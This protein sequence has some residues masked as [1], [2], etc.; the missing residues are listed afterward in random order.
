MEQII[1][2]GK[3]VA[4]Y[5]RQAVAAKIANAKARGLLTTLAVIVVGDDQACHVY[6]KRLVKLLTSLGGQVKEVLRPASTTQEEVVALV[7]KLNRNRYVT[8]ILPLLPMPPQIKGAE[9]AGIIAANKDVDCF[10]SSNMGEFY[11]GRNPWAPCT[12][13]ACLA[14]LD[15]YH[16]PLAGKRVVIIG[17]SNVVGK[18]LALLCL[19][20][21]ATVT[22][23]HSKTQDLPAVAREGDILISAV[24][25]AGFVTAEMVKEGAVLVDVGINVVPA[26]EGAGSLVVGDIAPEA[27]AKAAAYTPVPGGVGVVSNVMMAEALCRHLQ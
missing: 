24:G 18:P 21:N 16:I 11:A 20:R 4:A 17:R 15:H 22:V 12:P 10:N 26:P 8:G 19:Q 1:M 27:L 2:A 13:R 3:P 14:I 5:Y 7:K 25:R 23:C 9:V 6:E